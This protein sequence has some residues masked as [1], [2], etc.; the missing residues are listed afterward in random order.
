VGVRVV[1]DVYRISFGGLD[2]PALLQEGFGVPPFGRRDLDTRDEGAL[3]DPP[4]P[5]GTLA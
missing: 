1:A 4:S 2:S 5:F 3:G